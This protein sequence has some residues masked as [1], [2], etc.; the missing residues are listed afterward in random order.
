MPGYG[1]VLGYGSVQ[2]IGEKIAL[3]WMFIADIEQ[4]S[5]PSWA[6]LLLDCWLPR[7]ACKDLNALCSLQM[8]R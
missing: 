1:T 5:C 6:W 4:L 8:V 7:K 3:L 2:C